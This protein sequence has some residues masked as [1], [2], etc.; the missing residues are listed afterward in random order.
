[1]DFHGNINLRNNEMQRMVLQVETVFPET[2]VVGRLVFKNKRVYI[3]VEIIGGVPAWVP[4]TNFVD[5]YIHDQVQTNTTWT[6]VHNLNTT[7]PL[8]QVY[9]DDMQLLIPETVSPVDNNTMSVTF[10]TAISGR[11]I[12]MKGM[13]ADDDLYGGTILPE[14][15]AYKYTQS[16]ASATWVVRHRL[17]Y[18]PIVTVFDD[19]DDEIVPQNI[20]HDDIFQTTI[21]FSSA[22]TG[23]ARFV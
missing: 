6:V 14:P 2:P 22:L 17:G 4:L 12:A 23:S 10:G 20:S 5:T 15:S 19:N 13:Q 16:S 21:T 1:M 11:A 8:I 3:C 9:D 18:N 7:N